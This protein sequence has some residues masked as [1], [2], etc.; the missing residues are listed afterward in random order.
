MKVSIKGIE[1]T[2]RKLN[3]EFKAKRREQ[4]K[5]VADSLVKALEDATPVDTG[6]A[7]SRWKAEIIGDKAVITNDAPYIDELNRGSSQQAPAF[8][9]EKTVLENKKVVPNGTIV[10]YR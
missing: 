10:S 8:F 4:L 3:V 1:A 5:P 9:I 2:M 7:S 6:Y